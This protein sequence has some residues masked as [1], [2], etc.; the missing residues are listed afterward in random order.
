MKISECKETEPLPKVQELVESRI[1]I[2]TL[3]SVIHG[4]GTGKHL[5]GC[6]LSIGRIT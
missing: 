3:N 1:I 6:L 2:G 4:K 5:F